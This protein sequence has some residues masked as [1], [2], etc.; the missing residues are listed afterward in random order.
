MP[1]MSTGTAAPAGPGRRASALPLRSRLIPI[2]AAC[3]VVCAAGPADAQLDGLSEIGH[4][5]QSDARG[6]SEVSIGDTAL[7]HVRQPASVLYSPEGRLDTKFTNIF[8]D[9]R[10][11]LSGRPQTSTV[12]S[13]F[14]YNV[15]LIGP[16]AENLSGGIAFETGGGRS[17]FPGRGLPLGSPLRAGAGVDHANYELYASLGTRLTDRWWI[18]AGPHVEITTLAF[19]LPIAQGLL[20]LPGTESIGAGY[21]IGT[22]YNITER[23]RFGLSYDSPSYMGP[24]TNPNAELLRPDGTSVVGPLSI[25]PFTLPGRVSFG[26]SR[27]VGEKM[28][29]A[30]EGAY[31]DYASSLFGNI[32]TEGLRSGQFSPGYNDIWVVNAGLDYELSERWSGSIGFVY[33]TDPID[34]DAFVPIFASNAQYQ[35]TYGLRYTRGKFWVGFA[36]IISLPATTTSLAT[37]QPTLGPA[38]QSSSIDLMLQSVNCGFGFNF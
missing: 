34:A 19:G 15:G 11:S 2:A 12:R 38:Y 7:A 36:H 32:Q 3:S 20:R 27:S 9:Q 24:L 22:L 16:L 5:F 31:L 18:G 35:F 25:R 6:G 26:L 29:V 21:Q 1:I 8:P 10:W 14:S 4:S 28:K 30:L 23:L 37:T 13:E 17:N 33:N